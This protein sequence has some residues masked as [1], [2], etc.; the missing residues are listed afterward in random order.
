MISISMIESFTGVANDWIT[1]TSFSRTLSPIR[2][3]VLSLVNLKTS[4][5][6][7]G[8]PMYSQTA[9]V[10]SGFELPP[11]MVSWS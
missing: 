9:S 1:K 5:R 8:I 6:P 7:R 2:T 4:A 11:K 3:K 10:R